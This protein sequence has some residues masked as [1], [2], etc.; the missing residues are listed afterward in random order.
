MKLKGIAIKG[1]RIDKKT[2][3]PTKIDKG[4]VSQKIARKKKPKQT[5]KRG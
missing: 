2:G 3:R 4:S 1:Y 5:Y